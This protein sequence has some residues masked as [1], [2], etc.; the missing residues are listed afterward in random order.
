MSSRIDVDCERARRALEAIRQNRRSQTPATLADAA[1]ALGY[2]ID[3]KRGK[4]SHWWAKRPGRT[5]FPIPTGRTPVSV[6]VTTRILGILEEVFDD[7]C[8]R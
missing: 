3:R 5:R 7:V 1:E 2:E 8:K 4:G 6:G